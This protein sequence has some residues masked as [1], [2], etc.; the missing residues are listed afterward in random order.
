MGTTVASLLS[1]AP[2]LVSLSRHKTWTFSIGGVLIAMS[3]VMTYLVALAYGR[4]KPAMPTTQQRAER[5]ARLVESSYGD[6]PSSGHA[7]SSSRTCSGRSLS[8]WTTR[9]NQGTVITTE[10]AHALVS[11][12]VEKSA[13]P[14]RLLHET[15]HS[16]VITATLVFLLRFQPKKHVSS[17]KAS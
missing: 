13:S 16:I 1:A 3:F 14:A 2:W 12:A 5:S 4:A 17:P 6:Q 8:K 7:A 11:S 9:Q 15:T 10:A